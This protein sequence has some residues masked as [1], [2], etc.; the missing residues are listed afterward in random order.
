MSRNHKLL[1][2][3]LA[4]L[5]I[6]TGFF[7]EFVFLNVNE[8]MRVTYYNSP[9]PHVAPSMQWLESFSYTT[10]YYMKWFLTLVFTIVFAL[11]GSF[12][13]N[14]IFRDKK[15]VRLSLIAYASV[16]FASFLFFLVGAI[17]GNTEATYAIARFLAGIIE[18]PAMLIILLGA[19]TI[20]RR[21]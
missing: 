20:I 5:F 11:L 19:F 4:I 15:L 18:S 10:L 16:F 9:D 8:Q 14:T 7:R 1:I 12:I 6:L 13:V 2:A 17:S 3:T 21:N